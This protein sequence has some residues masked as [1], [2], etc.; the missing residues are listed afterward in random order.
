[1]NHQKRQKEAEKAEEII[2]RESELF[3]NK[4]KAA[5]IAPTIRD[6]QQQ[7]DR[8]RSH[9]IELTLKK[10]GPL[11]TEQKEALEQLT[12]SLTNKILQRSYS[13]LRQLAN[14]PDGLEKIELIRKL[15]RL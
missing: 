11:S 2:L 14:Q 5:D 1:M 10:M 3:W 15:F 13:E 12:A 8:L 9:E 4:L 7:I 6:I